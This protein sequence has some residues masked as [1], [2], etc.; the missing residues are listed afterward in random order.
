MS[1]YNREIGLLGMLLAAVPHFSFGF[2]SSL[3]YGGYIEILWLGNIILLITH[4]L[5]VQKEIPSLLSLFFLGLLWGVAWWTYPIS[6]VYLISSFC[7]LLFFKMELIR[8]GKGLD[9]RLRIFSGQYP[10]LDL[11]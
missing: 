5:A 7:F 3:V 9:R 6:I 4:R 11:E 10:L 2:Y 8:N 1:S